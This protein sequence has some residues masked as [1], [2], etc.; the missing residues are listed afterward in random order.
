MQIDLNN[1]L[2]IKALLYDEMKKIEYAEVHI[3]NPARQTIEYLS[4]KLQELI[5]KENTPV[6]IGFDNTD[7]SDE[8]I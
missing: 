5:E 8:W 6:S 3:I 7:S 4:K 2:Q 1:K